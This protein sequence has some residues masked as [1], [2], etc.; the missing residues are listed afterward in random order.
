MERSLEKGA[1]RPGRT[2]SCQ[3]RM[4]GSHAISVERPSF[5]PASLFHEV[6][7]VKATESEDAEAIKHYPQLKAF[8]CNGKVGPV[9]QM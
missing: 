6:C 8:L 7:K 4:R 9:C 1:N 2:G 3:T 5:L